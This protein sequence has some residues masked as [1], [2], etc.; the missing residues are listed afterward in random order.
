MSWW[1]RNY[2]AVAA[3]ASADICYVVILAVNTH[4][5]AL[6][7]LISRSGQFAMLSV[8][9]YWHSAVIYSLL[10][11]ATRAAAEL[12]INPEDRHFSS[13]TEWTSSGRCISLQAPLMDCWRINRDK[14]SVFHFPLGHYKTESRLFEKA[15]ITDI[16]F[17]GS[18][19]TRTGN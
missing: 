13:L 16:T 6:Q 3:F 5:S 11:P 10:L 4:K 17:R 15:N 2:Y 7:L 9:L 18:G 12:G 1:Q 19:E 8:F 14:L